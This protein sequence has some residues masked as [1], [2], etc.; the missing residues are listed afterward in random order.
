M[1]YGAF[2]SRT[3]LDAG[4]DSV[5]QNPSPD[6]QADPVSQSATASA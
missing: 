5:Q 6:S 4:T 3:N 2:V 1:N